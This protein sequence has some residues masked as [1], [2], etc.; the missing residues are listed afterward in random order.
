MANIAILGCSTAWIP[1]VVTDLMSVFEEPLEIRLIDLN[2]D[3]AKLGAE[4]CEAASKHHGRNDHIVPTTD[5]REGLKY[6][7]AAMITL[8]VGG[9]KHMEYDVTIPEKYGIYTTVGDTTGPAGWSRAIRNI[10]AF[11]DFARDFAEVCPTAFIVNYSN[12][13]A[14]LTAAIQHCCPNPVVGL[15]HSYFEIK[16]VIQKIFGLDDWSKISIA[17]AGMNHFTWVADFKIGRD[18]GYQLLR[19]KVGDG[20]LRD[21]W[22]KKEGTGVDLYSGSEL[23]AELYDLFG[24]LPYPGDRHTSEF[25]SFTLSGN[26][27]RYTMERGEDLPLDMIRYC[28]I[29]RTAIAHRLVGMPE[30]EKN[31][32][33][34]IEGKKDFPKKSRETGAEMVHCYLHNKPM[35]DSVNVLN[36]GQIPGLPLDACVETLG[37]VDGLGVRPMLVADVAE[38]L[39][40]I[41]RPQAVC[42]KWITRGTLEGDRNLL[43]HALRLDPQCAA[44]KLHEVRSLADELLEHNKPFISF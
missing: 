9:L 4:W 44:L 19:E 37:V 31:V 29:K 1:S 27:E 20:S 23:C 38:T 13:M 12:P 39:L 15:C 42:Q 36:T 34:M 28:N 7:D 33:E 11:R 10:P 41:M 5:R 26:P 24:Y 2:P 17:I 40:E 21:I 22:P 18:D 30:R 43:V 6:A 32:R 8:A 25:L 35:T 3:A 14:A 16:D